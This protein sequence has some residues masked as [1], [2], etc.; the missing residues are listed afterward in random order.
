MNPYSPKSIPFFRILFLV[1]ALFLVSVV[2]ST[3]ARAA[4]VTVTDCSA[5]GGAAGRL[6]EVI[7]AAADGDT[8][9]FSCSGTITLTATLTIDKNLTLDGSGQTVT[10]SGGNA[11]RVLMIDLGMTVALNQLTVSGGTVTG[12]AGGIYNQGMLTITD[13]MIS[14]NSAT[15]GAGGIFNI[16]TLTVTNSTISGNS[17]T[18]GSGGGIY[19]NSSASLA[20]A[21]S[22]IS[23]NSAP[24]AGGG[25]YNNT[26]GTVAITNSTL[27]GNSASNGG[28][29]YNSSGTS[30][31][32]I[33]NS[34]F[35]NNSGALGGAIQNR[36][37]ASI[38]NS[39]FSG[40][41]ATNRGGAI[42]G[43]TGGVST[44]INS[45]LS[46]NGATNGGAGFFGIGTLNFSNTLIANSTSGVECSS[47]TIGTNL[48]NLVEDGSCSATLSGDPNLG[49]LANNGGPTQT[50]APLTGSLAIEAGDNTTCANAPVNGLDQR[51]VSRWQGVYCD[52]GAYEKGP[53]VV[54]DC[55]APSGYPGLLVE[56]IAAAAAGDTVTFSCSGTIVLNTTITQDKNLTLDGS[57]QTVTISGGNLVRVFYVNSGVTVT[58]KNLTIA[59]G[60][61]SGESGGGIANQGNLTITNSMISGNTA[62]TGDGG[63]IVNHGSGTLTVANSTFSGNT[64][65][66]GGGLINI[67]TATVT[68][69]TFSGNTANGGG[70]NNAG[71]LHYANSILANSTG[72]DCVNSG[73]IG[74]NL[75]NLVEDGSCSA[76]LSGDPNL[77]VLA[78]NGGSAQ[79]FALLTGSTAMDAGDDPT[80]AAAP[81][82][83][84]DQR[85]APRPLGAHCD[86]GAFEKVSTLVTNTNNSGVGSLRG[87]IDYA[88]TGDTITFAPGLSNGVILLASTLTLS[89]NMTV[90]GSA[91]EAQISISGNNAVRVFVINSDVTATLDSLKI[92]NGFISL[93]GG[94]GIYLLG[95]N[96]T[97]KNSTLSGNSA[98]AGG[99]IFNFGGNMTVENS[100]LSG[101]SAIISGGGGI[102]NSSGA[103]LTVQ[104][105]TLLGNT[106]TSGTGGAIFNDNSSTLSVV[107]STLSGNTAFNGGGIAN[108]DSNAVMIRNST[109]SGNAATYGGGIYNRS[110][111]AP[112]WW[113]TFGFINT[114]VANSTSGGD[115]DNTGTISTNTNNLVEDNSCA[116]FLSGDP[117]LGALA[118]N[119][120]PTQTFALLVGSPAI[121]AGD[122]ATC[123]AAPVSGFDQRG[124]TRP[125]DGDASGSSVCDIGAFE[126]G[127]LQCGIQGAAEPADYTFLGNVTL[128]VMGDGTDLNCLRVTDILYHHPSATTSLKT[129]K[130]WLIVALQA[131]QSTNTNPDFSINLTLPFATADAQDQLCRYTGSGWD[132]AADGFVSNTSITRNNISQFSAWTVGNNSSPTAI[133]LSRL[134]A[135]SA[136]SVPGLWLLLGVVLLLGL[137]GV[138]SQQQ[139]KNVSR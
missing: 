101:N 41:T 30:A 7:T 1:L 62:N 82:S 85:G 97:L 36:A 75:N 103:L 12:P 24:T 118:D 2:W 31:L 13:S 122:S 56:V 68:N 111:Y 83:G 61:V 128:Q 28:G 15:T 32:T 126:L 8:V 38:T 21:N 112:S 134:T 136:V 72:G 65:D 110:A 33:A 58:L 133:S 87:A 104:N 47:T 81:V 46:G 45:T 14:G 107:N 70:I 67:G 49:A 84:L 91:L 22:T 139:R 131:D 127:G 39:T 19:N 78:N 35:A 80:C 93:D 105:S 129:G 4:T 60:W 113:T 123:T 52:I 102:L 114:I 18:S 29:I 48:N 51:G 10:I 64:A 11:V 106:A 132:C 90:D 96:L 3:P 108:Q 125:T 17:T 99:G 95:G 137:A 117:N 34:T 27:S 37:T 54:S 43:W 5:P 94:G 119:G 50:F 98:D 26:S 76:T 66:N 135:F 77:G 79:T 53:T 57:G 71:T 121:D 116:P 74:T 89:R 130:Y 55:S 9:N 42:M 138:N 69:S 73:T 86:I 44:I 25:I 120:G 88:A 6:V 59:D 63:G 115:C 40:N 124:A 23:G 109:L 100:T 92:I 16:G 20:A